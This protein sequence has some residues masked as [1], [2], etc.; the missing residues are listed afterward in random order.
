M[1]EK[2]GLL[3]PPRDR[4][5]LAAAM[6]RV[7]ADPALGRRLARTARAR[8]DR[9][10]NCWENTRELGGLMDRLACEA[11]PSCQRLSKRR[12]PTAAERLP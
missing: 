3:V 4:A 5:A 11:I 1:H 9:C 12:E 10:F 7:L 8:L 6:A 2:S